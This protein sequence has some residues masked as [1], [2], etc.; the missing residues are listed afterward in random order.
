MSG[1][2]TAARGVVGHERVLAALLAA[3]AEGTLSHATLLTG[4]DGVG[5]TTVALALAETILDGSSWP[6]GLRAHPDHWLEDS[7]AERIGI[8]RVRAGGGDEVSGPSLQDFLALLPYA[9]GLRTAVI[10]RAD[11]LSEP[12]ANCVLKT[13]EEPPRGTFI[14]L[15]AAHPERMPAT[16]LSRCQSLALAPVPSAVVADWLR[17]THGVDPGLATTAAALCAGRPGRALAL[18]TSPGALAGEL[19]AIEALL[20]AGGGGRAAALRTAGAL[21]P[22]NTAEGRE[23]ALAQVAAWT[24]FLRD[25]AVAS[26]GAPELTLWTHYA[27]AAERWASALPQER[28]AYL[29]GR[30]IET[31]DQLAQYAVPRLTFEVLLL[32]ILAGD[33]APPRVIPPPRPA[34][35]P[36][37]DGPAPTTTT[38]RRPPRRR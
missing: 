6:G 13:L 20:A 25:V 35:V 16:I 15:C 29:L 33:P 17:G 10:G 38:R 26:A 32:D 5:K 2:A 18:A 36:A 12:A 3:H 30:C 24:M 9:G 7:D 19:S 14:V 11:R 28:V 1:A 21:A 23:R 8:D 34:G 4:P 27:A 37:G 22:P 31:S